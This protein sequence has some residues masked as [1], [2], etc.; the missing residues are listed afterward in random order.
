MGILHTWTKMQIVTSLLS[1]TSFSSLCLMLW[2]SLY[3]LL[4]QMCGI[5]H[6]KYM[7]IKANILSLF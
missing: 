1:C 5:R 2:A 7:F 6:M 4:R 3:I